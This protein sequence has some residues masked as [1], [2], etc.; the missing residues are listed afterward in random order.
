MGA[1]YTDFTVSGGIVWEGQLAANFRHEI[2]KFLVDAG[3]SDQVVTDV[4]SNIT[5]ETLKLWQTKVRK[6]D[7]ALDIHF[8]AA[9][10]AARG[11]EVIV[12][13]LYT[14]EEFKLASK[15][16]IITENC[17]QTKLRGNL[18]V[19]TEGQSA[20]GKLGWMRLNCET[21]LWEV[22]FPTNKE[23]FLAFQSRHIDLA[24]EVAKLL[25]EW[26]KEEI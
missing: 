9:G 5:A 13:D 7:L 3:F 16:A 14:K 24:A 11:V 20:R 8:N 10:P 1:R 6:T 18:G 21:V 23:D 2:Y 4:D 22:C 15:L 17:L 26:L 12:P 19:I 25:I